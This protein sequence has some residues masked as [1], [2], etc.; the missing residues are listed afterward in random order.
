MQLFALR[1][2]GVTLLPSLLASPAGMCQSATIPSVNFSSDGK[3]SFTLHARSFTQAGCC[4]T[5]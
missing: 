2:C 3:K 1:R 4:A 5:D